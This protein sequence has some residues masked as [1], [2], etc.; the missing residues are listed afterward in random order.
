MRDSDRRI[1]KLADQ[2]T[3]RERAVLVLRSWKEGRGE[4]PSWRRSMPE[5]Q[6]WEFNRLIE[7]MNGVNQHLMPLLLV[8]ALEAD[9]LTL[10]LG[11]LGVLA[12]WYVQAEDSAWLLRHECPESKLAADS[13][14][15][16]P[17]LP[18][19][20]LEADL[21]AL[22]D[23]ATE[24]VEPS[25]LD[26]LAVAQKERLREDLQEHRRYLVAAEVVIEEVRE[27]FGGEDPALPDTQ[28]ALDYA[29]ERL[30]EVRE[31]A[32][33][34]LGPFDDVELDDELLAQTRRL[35]GLDG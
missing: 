26:G 29:R 21:K 30:D 7:L 20:H 10:R 3:A 19:M 4:D 22:V 34:F 23:E 27:E 18:V 33:R 17:R 2:F 16:A 32:T 5:G 24:G 8:L 1:A 15:N 35:V 31:D 25:K 11:V 13:L 12:L 6:A 9:K 14:T 28:R